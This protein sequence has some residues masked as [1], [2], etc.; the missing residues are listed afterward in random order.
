M[1]MDPRRPLDR[2][3]RVRLPRD[4]ADRLP[5][6]CLELESGTARLLDVSRHGLRVLAAG[7]ARADDRL[8]LALPGRDGA[9]AVVDAVIRWWQA[10][11]GGQGEGGLRVVPESLPAWHEILETHVGPAVAGADALVKAPQVEDVPRIAVLGPDAEATAAV[12]AR[13]AA[14]GLGA[15]V[16]PVEFSPA[17]GSEP[18]VVVAGPFASVEAAH[19][20]L[21]RLTQR[22]T[23]EGATIL[24]LLPGASVSERRAL[25]EAGAFDCL[26]ERDWAEALD[27]RLVVAL[28]LVESRRA[29]RIA[30]DRLLDICGRDPLTGLA[31]RRQFLSL[32]AEERKRAQRAG[33]PIAL[34]LLDVDHFKSVND[35]YGHAAG[36]SALRALSRL[37]RRHLRPFDLMG[38][39]GGEEF[40][41]LLSGAGQ[42]GALT[43]AERLRSLIASTPF[44]VQGIIR[45]TA[46]IGVVAVDPPHE[47]PFA[48]LLAAAD[49]ALYR[50]KH[51]GRNQ[52]RPGIVGSAAAART[53][54]AV[55][56]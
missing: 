29:T 22:P 50:A 12:A 46:S 4:I 31:N 6:E 42:S 8:S 23:L 56:V 35:L 15:A 16:V 17:S 14:T 45:L 18:I 7:E 10:P 2:E 52:V 36:D 34:L 28:R 53:P 55:S 11:P 30:T 47:V 9:T 21:G 39:Y 37:L 5:I 48:T 19:A 38:R 49:R 40:V 13:L 54:H 44:D 43:A 20:T 33:E 25:L 24:V 51:S 27:L 41:I 1:S 32:A 3:P 26:A